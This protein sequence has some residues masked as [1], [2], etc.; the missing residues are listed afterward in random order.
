MS[1]ELGSAHDVVQS[2]LPSNI[3]QA[4]ASCEGPCDSKPMVL[5]LVFL[6]NGL[7]QPIK[8]TDSEHQHTAYG[9]LHLNV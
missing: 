4:I 3:V 1:F 2:V 7:G 6:W 5:L 9:A 8:G